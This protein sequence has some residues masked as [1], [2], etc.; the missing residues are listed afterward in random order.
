MNWF[1]LVTNK[2]TPT[3]NILLGLLPIRAQKVGLISKFAEMNLSAIA[4]RNQNLNLNEQCGECH[5]LNTP[6]VIQNSISM[7]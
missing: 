6:S 4:F 7:L 1:G 3:H 2:Q 5:Y